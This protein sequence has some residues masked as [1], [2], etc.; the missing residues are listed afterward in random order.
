MTGEG[1]F[2]YLEIR[3]RERGRKFES[4]FFKERKGRIEGKVTLLF[5]PVID[6]RVSLFACSFINANVCALYL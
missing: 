6:S 4:N 2:C 5:P 1:F 3:G